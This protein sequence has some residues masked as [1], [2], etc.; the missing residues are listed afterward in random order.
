MTAVELQNP[1]G[2]VVEEVAVV[3]HGDHGR[4]IF[5]E[6]MFQPG[7]RLGVEMV[8]GLIEQQHVGLREQ[9]PAESDP[10][11][12]AAGQLADDGVPGRQA[13]RIRG[14]LELALELPAVD[15]VDPILELRL[16]LER[17]G[18]LVVGHRLRK[19]VADRVELVDQP[20][21]IPDTFAHDLAHG[22]GLVQHGL[23]RQIADLDAGLGTRLAFDFLVDAGHDLEQGGFAGA[24]QTEHADFGTG[25]KAQADVAQDD[26]LGR[27][28]LA[29][30]VH[31]VNEL[32]HV[33]PIP[34]T[35]LRGGTPG[36][37]QRS[38]SKSNPCEPS[39][40]PLGSPCSSLPSLGRVRGR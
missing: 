1:F 40:E 25:E 15:R 37:S 13:Q 24:V 26:A 35:L 39:G 34:K 14:N 3:R 8:G 9:Q 33:L 2:D 16:F 31:G 36:L 12:L 21:N 11:P 6:E 4:R 10:A 38:G 18:H 28:D 23:L 32:S 17:L 5:L 20:L 30:P 7:D 27:H 22:S 19:A 29:N